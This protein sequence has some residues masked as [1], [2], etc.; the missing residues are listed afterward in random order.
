[1]N[2]RE[3]LSILLGGGKKPVLV[4]IPKDTTNRPKR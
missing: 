3:L 1:M 2:L 4:P